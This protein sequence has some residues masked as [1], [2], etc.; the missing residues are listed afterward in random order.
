MGRSIPVY[1]LLTLRLWSLIPVTAICIV[2]N[3]GLDD[4]GN[5]VLFSEGNEMFLF[6]TTYRPTM[7]VTQPPIQRAVEVKRRIVQRII[8]TWFFQ[9]SCWYVENNFWQANKALDQRDKH[10]N[11]NTIYVPATDEKQLHHLV[12]WLS[13]YRLSSVASCCIKS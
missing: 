2:A 7:G 10:R 12:P 11:H 3:Y 8:S 9:H 6:S 5:M 1:L 4:R 13:T